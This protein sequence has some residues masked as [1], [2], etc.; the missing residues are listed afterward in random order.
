MTELPRQIVNLSGFCQKR[1][2]WKLK[3]W[4]FW[5]F[6]IFLTFPIWVE[7][8]LNSTFCIILCFC[9]SKRNTQQGK[10]GWYHDGD[11][12]YWTIQCE[13]FAQSDLT[14]NFWN[15]FTK[16]TASKILTSCC[17]IQYIHWEVRYRELLLNGISLQFKESKSKSKTKSASMT[18]HIRSTIISLLFF[19]L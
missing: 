17:H 16:H 1:T 9:L 7:R 14:S 11:I 4:S 12:E 15:I 6:G 3:R 10:N 5:N 18:F 13:M 2:N 8:P 19:F